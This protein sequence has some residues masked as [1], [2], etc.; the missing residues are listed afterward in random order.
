M[1]KIKC[2]FLPENVSSRVDLRVDVRGGSAVTKRL[3][4]VCRTTGTDYVPVNG[5]GSL[6]PK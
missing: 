3:K 6:R 2:N 1:C 4:E 5:S